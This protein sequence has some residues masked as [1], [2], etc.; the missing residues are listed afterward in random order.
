AARGVEEL[1]LGIIEERG[2]TC[3]IVTHNRSQAARMAGR[4]M[5]LEAGRLIAVGPTPEMLDAH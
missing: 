1:V 4:T 3:V 2:L 5:V